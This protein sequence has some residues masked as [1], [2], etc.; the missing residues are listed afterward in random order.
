MNLQN[1]KV[2]VIGI[3]RSGIAVAKFLKEKGAEVILTD[4][5]ERVQLGTVVGELETAGITLVLGQ[6]PEINK[7]E[8]SFIVV[9]P[10]VPLTIE[11]IQKAY[12]Q[13]IPIY[14]EV[15]IASRYAKAPIVAITGTNGKTTTTS[16]IGEMFENAGLKT[17]V[18]GNIG[19][20]VI[21][22]VEAFDQQDI[23]I[24]E[25]SSFQLETT[26]EF[27][28]KVGVF[29]N[30]TPD[31]LDR[32]GNLAN[33]TA[34][35]AKVFANQDNNDFTVL[36]FDDQRV[37]A[38]AKETKGKVIFFSRKHILEEGVYVEEGQIVVT[39][40]GTTQVICPINDVKIPGNHN[41]ENALAAVAA[42]ISQ[43]LETLV[44]SNTLRTFGGVSH[45]LEFV[46]EVNGVRFINDSKG[47]NP[48]ASIKALEAYPEPIVL[49]AG[50]KNKGSDF[51]EFADKIKVK[52]KELV[53]IGQAAPQIKEAVENIGFT[54]IHEAK[55]YPEAVKMANQ[56]ACPGDI[57]LLSPACASWDMFNS[58]EE[59][60][61]L[62]KQVVNDLRR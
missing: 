44:I 8:L 49:I 41:L 59:R 58:Y 3:A 26:K 17:F 5:K 28:P 38:L 37:A 60:G 22:K 2:L 39:V 34:A 9:S 24:A 27:K 29:L 16:L 25:V 50:G 54:N 56:V 30:L 36:N 47:T 11:P 18:A 57:V 55:D 10:G 20:P 52:V 48:D 61:N 14:S 43:G 33:Y 31:H 19:V 15:E 51:G 4:I 62:F 45:R 1:E 23:I 32:H 21:E 12:Q 40:N 6:H 13:A 46:A 42:G 35:K 7:E 53:L